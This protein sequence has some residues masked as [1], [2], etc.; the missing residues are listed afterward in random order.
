[1]LWRHLQQVLVLFFYHKTF[2][3]WKRQIKP[4]IYYNL[5]WDT[6]TECFNFQVQGVWLPHH[7]PDR[8]ML[9]S[10]LRLHSWIVAVYH[11]M[12]VLV[13]EACLRWKISSSPFAYFQDDNYIIRGGK[14]QS[15]LWFQSRFALYFGTLNFRSNVCPSK[16]Y[17]SL[18][19]KTHSGLMKGSKHWICSELWPPLKRN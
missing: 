8:C 16:S 13:C 10:A 18:T 2:N 14:S 7:H 19:P 11:T 9:T 6:M 4:K 1:M 3:D 5:C 15:C 12:T 17:Y